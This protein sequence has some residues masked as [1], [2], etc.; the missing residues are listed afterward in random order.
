VAIWPQIYTFL[1]GDF[2]T[3]EILWRPYFEN[4]PIKRETVLYRDSKFHSSFILADMG[5]Q[6][7]FQVQQ[8]TTVCLGFR[9]RQIPRVAH[10]AS[11][12]VDDTSRTVTNFSPIGIKPIVNL[13]LSIIC[14]DKFGRWE[15][16]SRYFLLQQCVHL[17][18]NLF[19][20]FVKIRGYRNGEMQNVTNCT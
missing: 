5:I 13:L 6:G 15:Q 10:F 1:M 12:I 11:V 2:L 7:S 19:N 9:W 14:E 18:P 20:F 17:E 3:G 4:D 8:V 16:L